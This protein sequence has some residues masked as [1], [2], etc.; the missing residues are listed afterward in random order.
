MSDST[1]MTNG[2]P[3]KDTII[4]IYRSKQSINSSEERC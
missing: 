3:K 1:K 4:T 2:E